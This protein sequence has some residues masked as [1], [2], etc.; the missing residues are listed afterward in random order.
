VLGGEA[1]PDA[2]LMALSTV[3]GG[4]AAEAL[5][6]LTAGGPANLAQLAKFL[7]DTVLGGGEGF[8]APQATPE[9]GVHGDREQR[10]G[11]PPSASSSTEPTSC[12]VHSVRRHPRRR[13]RT[14]GANALPSTAARCE[15]CRTQPARGW[16]SS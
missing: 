11:R 4:V 7:T 8:E 14:C 13:P 5:N 1:V 6:Y 10:E 15:A 9:F 2:E 12:R 16:S 3:P